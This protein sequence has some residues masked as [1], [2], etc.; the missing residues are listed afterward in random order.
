MC[1]YDQ[2]IIELFFPKSQ[3]FIVGMK[4]FKIQDV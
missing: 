2:Q 1:W 4:D 3:I